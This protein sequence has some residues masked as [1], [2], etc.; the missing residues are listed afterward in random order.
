MIRGGKNDHIET[1]WICYIDI[2][3]NLGSPVYLGN[4]WF[5]LTLK[6]KWK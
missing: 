1:F 2:P 4:N 3:F 5:L 6:R